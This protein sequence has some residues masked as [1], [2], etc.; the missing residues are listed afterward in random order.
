MGSCLQCQRVS[1]WSSSWDAWCQAGRHGTKAVA[2]SYIPRQEA[3][4]KSTNWT[5]WACGISKLIPS[6]TAPQ[7]DCYTSWSFPNNS[8]SSGL[9]MQIYEPMQTTLI[10]PPHY[11]MM[12]FFCVTSLKLWNEIYLKEFCFAYFHTDSPQC[13]FVFIVFTFCIWALSKGKKLFRISD[14]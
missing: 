13:E 11:I 8:T 10:K 9:N 3:E 1:S 12:L 2:G 5:P 4:R 6:D 7:Q 14:M